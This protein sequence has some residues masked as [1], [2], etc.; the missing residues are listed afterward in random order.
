MGQLLLFLTQ[1]K[2]CG[3]VPRIDSDRSRVAR[4]IAVSRVESGD[5]C[6]CE[7]DV[8]ALEPGVHI[9]EFVCGLLL[10]AIEAVKRMGRKGRAEKEKE[11]P[12]R[13]LAV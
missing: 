8:R 5:E 3:D 12:G 9:C 4:R 1:L 7:G 2:P 10:L 6:A 13:N 11:T